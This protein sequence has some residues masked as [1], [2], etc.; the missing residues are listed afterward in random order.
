MTV[1]CPRVNGRGVGVATEW[2]AVSSDCDSVDISVS[3]C[4]CDWRSVTIPED[5]STLSPPLPPVPF[6]PV[7]RATR[8]GTVA[9][10][11]LPKLCPF[12][13]LPTQFFELLLPR[14]P[15]S[16]RPQVVSA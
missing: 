7:T 9:S 11:T 4:A 8:W 5:G 2:G 14:G 1:G 13:S 10:F 15:P 6:F 16:A 3:L 12:L